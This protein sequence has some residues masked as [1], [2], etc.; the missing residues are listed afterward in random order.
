M[1]K[2]LDLAWNTVARVKV[3]GGYKIYRNTSDSWSTGNLLL[4]TVDTNNYSDDGTETSTDDQPM[5]LTLEKV[6]ALPVGENSIIF[7]VPA[8]GTEGGEPTYLGSHS[9]RIQLEGFFFGSI[10]KTKL[11]QLRFIRVGGVA[12]RM[13]FPPLVKHGC[14]AII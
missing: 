5:T 8:I 13:T 3:T 2:T 12:C 10:A 6:M 7:D 4:K 1:N 9:Q 11:D 14:R